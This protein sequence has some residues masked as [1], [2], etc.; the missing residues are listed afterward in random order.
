LFAPNVHAI[1]LT[2]G[3]ID[4]TKNLNIV[5]PGAKKLTISGNDASRVFHIESGN[6]VNISN[7]TIADGLASGQLPASVVGVVPGSGAGGGGGILNE[8]GAHLTLT[9][10][11]FS[12]NQAIHGSSD[13][14]AFTVLGGGLLNLGTAIVTGCQ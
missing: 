12:D 1:T 9:N 2:L 5:G 11:T 7:L 10:D 6:T 4:I 3:E 13:S 14:S 8:A